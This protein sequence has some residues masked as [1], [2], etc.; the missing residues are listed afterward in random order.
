MTEIISFPVRMRFTALR[1][2]DV[3]SGI[4][5]VVGVFWA[6]EQRVRRNSHCGEHQ[7][8]HPALAELEPATGQAIAA[9]SICPAVPCNREG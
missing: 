4:G 7:H 8:V 2:F 6:P 1:V 5:S 9:V 3:Q